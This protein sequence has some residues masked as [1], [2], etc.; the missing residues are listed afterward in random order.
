MTDI[1]YIVESL[2]IEFFQ[3]SLD[4]QSDSRQ[5]PEY[6]ESQNIHDGTKF[7]L[8]KDFVYYLIILSLHD[9]DQSYKSMQK[10]FDR[11]GPIFDSFSKN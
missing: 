2:N 9:E 4:K 3:N 6:Y 7:V 5:V 1:K 10:F 8:L 11:I